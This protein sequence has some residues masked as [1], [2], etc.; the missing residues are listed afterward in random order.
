[1]CQ[2]Y[3]ITGVD[4]HEGMLSLTIVIILQSSANSYMASLISLKIK[5]FD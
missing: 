2:K 1:M 3:S 4:H 5:N